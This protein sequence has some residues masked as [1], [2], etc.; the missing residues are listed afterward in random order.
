MNNLIKWPFGNDLFPNVKNIFE[1]FWADTPDFMNR[2]I[3]TGTTL[4]A[5]NIHETE[6]AYEIELAVPG[7][8][9]E[10]LKI[11][12]DNHRLLISSEQKTEKEA[13]EKNYTRREFSFQTFQRS[14][15]LPE[16]AQPD[17]IGA[18]Y[19]EGVLHVSVPRKAQTPDAE[20]REINIQ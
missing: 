12:L 14:F 1:D 17:G 9:K 16:D 13:K 8:K 15:T 18:K 20:Q 4:P 7:L 10:D 3:H 5:A 19:D 6:N 11:K 2:M